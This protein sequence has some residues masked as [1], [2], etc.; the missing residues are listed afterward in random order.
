[1][2]EDGLY[3]NEF[4][5]RI[6]NA[7]FNIA[8]KILGILVERELTFELKIIYSICSSYVSSIIVCGYIFM[9]YYNG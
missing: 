9:H 6:F 2:H 8:R 4:N 7:G 5:E 3:D 1:M